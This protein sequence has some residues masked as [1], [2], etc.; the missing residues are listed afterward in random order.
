[1]AGCRRGACRALRAGRGARGRAAHAGGDWLHC[2][3]GLLW[4]GGTARTGLWHRCW[5]EP[6]VGSSE[7]SVTG[8][9]GP[10][11][12]QG[13]A[14]SRRRGAEDR[15]S[16]GGR[17]AA[18]APAPPAGDATSHEREPGSQ[19]RPPR[20]P[21][22]TGRTDGRGTTCHGAARTWLCPSPAHAEAVEVRG[23]RQRQGGDGPAGPGRRAVPGMSHPPLPFTT[24]RCRLLPR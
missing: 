4:S 18:P 14:G 13:L 9:R 15:P 21:P 5:A 3:R 16:R 24:P 11:C 8:P 17:G 6:V 7:Q 22:L 12:Q 19:P 1:M 20:P 10:R 23:C 2:W